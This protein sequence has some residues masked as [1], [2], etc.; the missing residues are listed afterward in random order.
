[1]ARPLRIEFPGALYH[2]TSR[3]DRREDI[4][5]NDDDRETFLGVL[6]RVV[7]DY[8]WLCHSYCL[9]SNHYHLIV[10]TM[11]RHLGK[12]K[13]DLNIPRL[14][15]RPVVLPL[16]ELDEKAANRNEAVREAY[17]TGGYSQRE[18]GEYF[19]L[20]PSTVGVII[21]KQRTSLFAT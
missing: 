16:Q 21:R 2:V 7:I 18:I 11:Q 17:A 6:G 1:M 12:E 15:K 13:E 5:E 20:H 10:E 14:Q 19:G 8:H 4:F 3:G 9:L